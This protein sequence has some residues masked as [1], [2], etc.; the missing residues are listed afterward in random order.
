[1]K[2]SYVVVLSIWGPVLG[3]AIGGLIAIMIS[4][5]FGFHGG[6][7]IMIGKIAAII[8]GSISVFLLIRPGVIERLLMEI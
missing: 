6:D 5:Q 4:W 2:T 3:A 1:M 7:S 8:T